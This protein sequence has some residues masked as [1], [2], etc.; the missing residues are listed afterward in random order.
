MLVLS[1]VLGGILMIAVGVAVGLIVE[2]IFFALAAFGVVDFALAWL[3]A[4]G[5]IGPGAKRRR[6][7]AAGAAGA[8]AA[9]AQADPSYNPYARED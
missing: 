9:E 5:R 6:A 1:L 3:F 2:P 8:A 4:S 7:E